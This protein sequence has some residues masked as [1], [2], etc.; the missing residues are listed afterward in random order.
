MSTYKPRAKRERGRESAS[1][2]NE[3]FFPGQSPRAVW[4]PGVIISVCRNK[5]ASDDARG[6]AE[7]YGGSSVCGQSRAS[8]AK[9]KDGAA[10]R[11]G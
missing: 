8:T 9:Q 5:F 4:R 2:D 3:H 1:Q 6:A 7:R 10:V 11:L